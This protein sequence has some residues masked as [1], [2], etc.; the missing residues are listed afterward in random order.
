MVFSI[1]GTY[2]SPKKSQYS[3]EH[4]DSILE[5]D[6]MGYLDSNPSV[7]RWTKKHGIK[8]PYTFLGFK[9]DYLPDFLVILRDGSKEIHETKGLPFLLWLSV[10]IKRK[11]AEEWCK[12]WGYKYKFVTRSQI[13]FY[14][15]E[16]LSRLEGSQKLD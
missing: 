9:R 4:Y 12:N 13:P 1:S 7:S 15:P 10:K 11:S 8:I 16:G 3:S 6:Y 5:R 14:D 2:R